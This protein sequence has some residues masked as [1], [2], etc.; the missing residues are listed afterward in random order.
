MR[1][2]ANVLSYTA[3]RVLVRRWRSAISLALSSLLCLGSGALWLRSRSAQD[4]V[5]FSLR[6]PVWGAVSE[7]GIVRL[8]VDGRSERVEFRSGD[9]HCSGDGLMPEILDAGSGPMKLRKLGFA[10]SVS[11]NPPGVGDSRYVYFPHWF[12]VAATGLL[13]AQF[14]CS[15]VTRKLLAQRRGK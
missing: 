12:L 15:R 6:G 4:F 10:Y 14:L 1:D 9:V 3:R 7:R 8:D 5:E 11:H 13:P 2:S